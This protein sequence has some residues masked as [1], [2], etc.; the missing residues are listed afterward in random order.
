[1]ASMFLRYVIF[2]DSENAVVNASNTA[3]TAELD[4]AMKNAAE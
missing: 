2:A 1:M 4:A 3:E